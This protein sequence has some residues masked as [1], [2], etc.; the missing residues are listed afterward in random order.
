MYKLVDTLYMIRLLL[1]GSSVQPRGHVQDQASHP[2]PFPAQTE[3]CPAVQ[4]S[5]PRTC[6]QQ[7]NT[8]SQNGIPAK[9]PAVV[10]PWMKKVHVTTVNPDYTGAE[11]KR[12][13]TAYTRQQVLELEKEF[14]FNSTATCAF[15]QLFSQWSIGRRLNYEDRLRRNRGDKTT[16]CGQ[17][18]ENLW[19]APIT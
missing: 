18:T 7:Q 13:R 17:K 6:G 11:P 9:Q 10:Y 14:H 4:I 8:K 2:S 5:G 15:V 12:S 3:Q 19:E 16:D 1:E